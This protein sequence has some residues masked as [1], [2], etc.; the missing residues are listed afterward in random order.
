MKIHKMPWTWA[1][2]LDNGPKRK[3][4]DL[5]FGTWNVHTTVPLELWNSTANSNS[6]SLIT[7]VSPF[8]WL[9]CLCTN[10]CYKQTLII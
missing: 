9:C 2:S 3:K 5:R 10:Q 7:T 6:N 1:D 8:S 4:M